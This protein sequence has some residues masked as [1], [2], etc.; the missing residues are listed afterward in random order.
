MLQG[1]VISAH[2]YTRGFGIE[3]GFFAHQR[4]Q[5]LFIR[6]GHIESGTQALQLGRHFQAVAEQH[7]GFAQPFLLQGNVL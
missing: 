3:L 2:F 1:G 5:L 6:Q 4:Q 7:Q